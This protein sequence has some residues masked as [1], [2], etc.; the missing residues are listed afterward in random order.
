MPNGVLSNP[1]RLMDYGI[2]D[3]RDIRPVPVVS[4]GKGLCMSGAEEVPRHFRGRTK[5]LA[6]P[7]GCNI[8]LARGTSNLPY[9]GKILRGF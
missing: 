8:P 2:S 3:Q 9:S 4:P 6:F 1:V 7:K 5:A